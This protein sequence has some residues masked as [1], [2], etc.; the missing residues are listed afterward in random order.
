MQTIHCYC[1]ATLDYEPGVYDECPYCFSSLEFDTIQE[2]ENH[3]E[4]LLVAL[5]QA[6]YTGKIVWL[7][8]DELGEEKFL[9]DLRTEDDGLINLITSGYTLQYPEGQIRVEKEIDQHRAAE[10]QI[11]LDNC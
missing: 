2:I 10:R 3:N 7:L 6:V 1:G 9:R 4:D 8:I 11:M 5:E